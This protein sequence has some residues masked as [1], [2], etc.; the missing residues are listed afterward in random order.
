MH[1]IRQDAGRRAMEA[2]F[3]PHVYGQRKV[4]TE[5]SKL[6]EEGHLPHTMLFYGD[7]GLG[8]TSMAFDLAGRMT[9]QEGMPSLWEISRP[10]FED[11]EYAS[12]LLLEA[13]GQVWYLRPI[14][15]ELKMEQFRLFLE[16]MLS[17]DERDHIC[18]IDEAQTMMDPIANA[19]L[20]TLEEPRSNVY[21]ILISHDIQAVLPT[22]ISRSAKFSFFP[23]SEE[24]YA[25]LLQNQPERFR[26]GSEDMKQ[27]AWQIS[28]GNPGLTLD[29]LGNGSSEQ[30]QEA[31]KF[32]EIIT[33]SRTPFRGAQAL[34]PTDRDGLRRM[35]LWLLLVCRDLMVI[36]A[37]PQ[38]QMERCLQV[39]GRE[40]ELSGAWNGDSLDAAAQILETAER[41]CRRYISVKIIW[42]MLIIELLHI[43]KGN[44]IWNVL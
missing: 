31:M 16:A 25:K 38:E 28:G 8:K 2:D 33:N 29:M 26:F 36:H 21:F 7:E 24:E 6:A 10:W 42:D 23:L 12:D 1:R 39:S 18:I 5:L 17:F 43:R 13:R 15:M 3:F 37:A 11:K 14:K 32:W 27:A 44:K 35:L 34:L 41:A 4:K 22:I 19:L 30:P 40:R 9:D 20:K